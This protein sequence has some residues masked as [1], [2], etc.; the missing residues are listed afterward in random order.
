MEIEEMKERPEL[1]LRPAALY[2]FLQV[3][4]LLLLA[5]L[6]LGIAWWL[7]PLFI[8]PSLT[9]IIIAGYRFMFIRSIL[10]LITAE[11]IRIRTGIFSKRLD[12]L[13]MFRIK[14]YTVTQPLILQVFRLMNLTLKTTDPENKSMTLTGIPVSDI[15]DTI[16]SHVQDA[17]QHNRIFEVN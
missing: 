8:W 9:I 10:Y 7:F 14:D 16:R 4:P 2:A 15:I 6:F 13:E 1:V 17:R 11:V 5:L 3:L 12:N